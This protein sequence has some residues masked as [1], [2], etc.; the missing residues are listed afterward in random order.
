MLLGTLDGES[1]N[2]NPFQIAGNQSW[3]AQ[4]IAAAARRDS[5]KAGDEMHIRSGGAGGMQG[6]LG[7]P[8]RRHGPLQL[9]LLASGLSGRQIAQIAEGGEKGREGMTGG[10]DL[11]EANDKV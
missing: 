1:M 7:D 8:S 9:K 2:I 6:D 11:K 10:R 5:R 3:T 4:L